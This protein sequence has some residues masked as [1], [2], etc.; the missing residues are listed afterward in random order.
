MLDQIVHPTLGSKAPDA[1]TKLELAALINKTKVRSHSVARRLH[2]T[3][4]PLFAWAFSE[5]GAIESNPMIGLR[6]PKPETPR[7][8]VLRTSR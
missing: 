2:E 3:L 6:C 8:R 5:C 7:D 4:R 1:I